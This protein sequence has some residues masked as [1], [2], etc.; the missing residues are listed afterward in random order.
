MS[1]L[2]WLA[3]GQ[4]DIGSSFLSVPEVLGNVFGLTSAILG[5]RRWVLA[6]PIGLVGNVLLFFVFTT[7]S[8]AEVGEEPLWGQAGRQVFFA[9]VSLYGWWRWTRQRHSGG[10]ADGGA[11]TPRWA[12]WNERFLL[13]AVGAGVYALTYAALL[14]IGSWS[15][16][17]EAWIVA[18][19]MLATW[20]MARGWVEFWLVWMLVDVVGVVSL[21]RSPYPAHATVGMYLFYAFFVVMGFFVWWRAARDATPQTS[22]VTDPSLEGVGA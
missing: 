22:P 1:I 17:T 8:I 7:G 3:T 10:S 4:I 9:A 15:P 2:E 6:W 5:M 12:T 11:I 16:P 14:Q 18:G 13:L 21:V 19:S 20:G